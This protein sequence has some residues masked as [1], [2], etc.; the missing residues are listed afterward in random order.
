MK[1]YYIQLHDRSGPTAMSSTLKFVRKDLP[2]AKQLRHE[3]RY[4]LEPVNDLKA[5]AG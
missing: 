3:G 5:Y 1:D 2:D 4:F